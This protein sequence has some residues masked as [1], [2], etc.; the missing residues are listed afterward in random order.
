MRKLGEKRLPLTRVYRSLYSEDLFLTA[1]DKIGRN[2][3][4]LT[5]GT[6]TDTADGTDLKRIRGIIEK[7][8]YERFRFRPSRRTQVPKKQG[9]TRPLGIPNFSEKLVQ[10]VLRL[11]LEAYYEPRFR[12]SSHG[13]RPG[14]GCH[15]A[16]ESIKWRF[17]GST[18]FIEGD[19]RG[20]FDNIDHDVMMAILS[21]DI[22]DGRLLNLIRMCLKAGYME[23]WKYHQTYSGTPQGGILSPLLANIYLHELDAFIEDEL[24][25]QYMRGKQRAQ[26]REYCR[27]TGRIA[28][29]RQRGDSEAVRKLEQQR[30]RIPSQDVYDPQ[31]RRLKYVRY[32]DDFLLGFTGPKSEAEAIK[33]AIGQFL[34]KKLKLEMSES[35][36]LITHG[37]TEHAHFLGYAIS[38]YHADHK[39]SRRSGTRIKTRS[40]NGG[41]RL[42]IPYGLIDERAR[43]YQR[44]GKPVH[45]PALLVYSD[46]HIIDVYQKR[47]RGLA[48]YYKYAV[49]R[50]RLGKLNYV[51]EVALVKTLANKFR[52][53]TARIYRKYK[54]TRTVDGYTYKTLRVKVPTRKGTRCVYWGAIPL[55]V[56]KP[57]TESID[58][59]EYR[60]KMRATTSDLIQRLRADQC[61]L[62]GSHENCQVHHV[63]KLADLRERWKGRKEKPPWVKRMIA[64]RRKTLVVC[65]KC[66]V[67]IH[68]GKP[69]PSGRK[70]SSGEPD[71][72]K[73]SRPVRRGVQRNLT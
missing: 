44:G 52:T 56:V 13:F 71:E 4:A 34:E 3:G 38:V 55:K 9:G 19:I 50:H 41:I 27:L 47:S 22:H 2:K 58:D 11:L 1:Y 62:C 48:E 14:R 70:E 61:E 35:K 60:E 6:E 32:A 28:R 39:L 69:I 45:E 53:S 65:H 25:P 23:D 21:R 49:D 10:E 59:R 29:A 66:H 8:R 68:G 42:G 24:I 63:R 30:R 64:L 20:C 46:A 40:V 31:Y 72:R 36:T 33:A 15:T 5:P 16:L 12:D 57:G 54:G 37:R 7:L 18:W 17:R 67:A 51:M 73:R 43:R 26:N